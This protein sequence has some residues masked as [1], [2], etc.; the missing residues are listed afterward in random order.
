MRTIGL[1]LVLSAVCFG[2]F[3]LV[4]YLLDRQGRIIAQNLKGEMLDQELKKIFNP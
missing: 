4:D 2:V 3:V 1:F